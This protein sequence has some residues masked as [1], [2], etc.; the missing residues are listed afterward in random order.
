MSSSRRSRRRRKTIRQVR[1]FLL[2]TLLSLVIAAAT[3]FITGRVPSLIDDLISKQAT[4]R[5][6]KEKKPPTKEIGKDVSQGD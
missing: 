5:I 6:E 2:I 4:R 3:S 1:M